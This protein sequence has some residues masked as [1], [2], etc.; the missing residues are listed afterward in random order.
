MKLVDKKCIGFGPL[1]DR[2]EFHGA[3]QNRVALSDKA[4]QQHTANV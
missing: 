3:A 1:M 2:P 4:L